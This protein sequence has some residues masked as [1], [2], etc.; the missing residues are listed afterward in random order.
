MLPA[1]LR[2]TFRE[3]WM[4]TVETPLRE[5]WLWYVTAVGAAMILVVFI[6]SA[7]LQRVLQLPPLTHLGR[8]S[9]S[10]YLWHFTVLLCFTPR[11]L[12]GLNAVGLVSPAPANLVGLVGTVLA[13]VVVSDLSYRCIEKPCIA[14]GRRVSRRLF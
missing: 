13:T 1:A 5:A 6:G 8:I 3:T 11:F 4:W 12:H 10:V 2:P 7:R 14:L 9:Y